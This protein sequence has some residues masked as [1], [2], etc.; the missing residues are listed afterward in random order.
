MQ[1]RKLGE[2]VL[3]ALLF[4]FGIY[5][6]MFFSFTIQQ[7]FEAHRISLTLTE[8]SVVFDLG[9]DA[10]ENI[11]NECSQSSYQVLA[12]SFFGIISLFVLIVALWK[13]AQVARHDKKVSLIM[14]IYGLIW[15]IAPTAIVT[16]TIQ[17][18]KLYIGIDVGIS[19][20]DLA[21]LSQNF[22]FLDQFRYFSGAFLYEMRIAIYAL[23]I[24]LSSIYI[25][26]HTHYKKPSMRLYSL[27]MLIPFLI[28]AFSEV[29]FPLKSMVTY[30]EKIPLII[31]GEGFLGGKVLTELYLTI[32]QV[33][34]AIL[35]LLF[36]TICLEPF[37]KD[38]QSRR[39]SRI[40]TKKRVD[41]HVTQNRRVKIE[42]KYRHSYLKQE[43]SNYL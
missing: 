24:L 32:N 31:A 39:K 33:L 6:G 17:N 34:I 19:K 11:I 16:M 42:K 27:I 12:M 14:L 10:F 7:V 38:Y 2:Y 37:F 22:R 18:P 13:G 43:S 8:S 5:L 28:L 21:M 3:E 4:S 41:A 1:G 36:L 29:F 15:L 23:A 9:Y 40:C 26:M 35:L 20:S 25:S 30:G